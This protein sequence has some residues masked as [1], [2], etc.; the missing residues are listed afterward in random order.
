MTTAPV[1]EHRI[2]RMLVRDL[3]E[4]GDER[5][6][7]D[8][9]L[10]E[11]MASVARFGYAEP[12]MLD[13]RTGLLI[14]GHGRTEALALMEARAEDTTPVPAYVQR[15]TEG[16]TVPVIRGWASTDD[17]EAAAYLVASN[18]LTIAGGWVQDPLA[19]LLSAVAD[20]PG[21]LTG[22]GF[23]EH[24]V[25]DLLAA[26]APAPSL[27][28]LAGQHGTPDPSDFWPVLRF[29]IPPELRDRFTALT[30]AVAGGD[31]EAFT[32]LVEQAEHPG[33]R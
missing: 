5:N 17:D 11:L 16:W 10:D 13:E 32:W 31:V 2:E 4:L 25:A 18:Q 26:V 30:A 19:A 6:A 29:K 22:T 14:A 3:V 20:S 7:K 33:G 23:G 12:T 24:E 28:D 8:H 27:D 9:A 15:T 1:Q 21:G